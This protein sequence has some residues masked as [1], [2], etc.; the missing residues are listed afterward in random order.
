MPPYVSGICAETGP[1]APFLFTVSL[2]TLVGPGVASKAMNQAMPPT[3]MLGEEAL[4]YHIHGGHESLD[5]CRR[6]GSDQAKPT[7]RYT[8]RPSELPP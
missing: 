1:E 4:K 8:A 2:A 5:T 3:R 6:L 7:A